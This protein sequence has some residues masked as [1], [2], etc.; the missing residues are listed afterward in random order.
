MARQSGADE[1]FLLTIFKK[2]SNTLRPSRVLRHTSSD[3]YLFLSVI[4]FDEGG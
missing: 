4:A 1:S 3:I 2:D